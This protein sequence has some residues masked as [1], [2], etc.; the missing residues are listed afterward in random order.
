MTTITLDER[1]CGQGK[2]TDGIYKRIQHNLDKNI[3][4]L[5]AVPSLLLQEQYEKGL[6]F[7]VTLINSKNYNQPNYTT[8]VKSTLDSM[9]RGDNVIIITHKT[10]TM[11]P[12]NSNRKL[13]DL[14]ID[15]A[16]E[17]ILKI[18]NVTGHHKEVWSP[19]YD[20]NNLFS[21]E[22]K[23]I[24]QTI[25]L[26]KDDDEN[27]YRLYQD[28]TPSYSFISESPSFRTITDKNYVHYVTPKAWHILNNQDGGT[29][30]VISTLNPDIFKY[31][32]SVHIASAA[33]HFTEMYYWLRANN[34]FTQTQ[35]TFEK[36]KGN[37]KI[38]AS[39]NN[40]FK[41]SNTKRNSNPDILND[42]HKFVNENASGR[43][44][45]LR[46][47]GEMRML[48][49]EETIGHS[50]HGLNNPA[51]QNCNN[52]S[53]ESAL[54]MDNLTKKFII[55]NWLS[56]ILNRH[57]TKKALIHMRS[58]YL[59]YQV[60]MR[61]KLRNRDYNNERINIFVPDQDTAVCLMDYFDEIAD[62]GEMDITSKLVIGKP[63]RPQTSEEEKKLIK[64]E[65][66]QR[67]RLRQKL[68]IQKEVGK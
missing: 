39:D 57:E 54:V 41:W 61:T 22:N 4:T 55:D 58:A 13:Y 49:N 20:L 45:A 36:H 21:F 42:Y 65:Q 62:V 27:W 28:R 7:P 29:A 17:E 66:N 59:F 56:A 35:N 24:E 8:T 67:Y 26:S 46:N 51:L 60:V 12:N 2:T 23:T 10:F 53:L 31:Y 33:F 3:K 11:L 6:E 48:D 16:I 1:G 68:L 25:E 64:K 14:I 40:K 18:T 43:V 9:E 44:I 15:E 63:G 19:N 30:C 37:I 32:K 5:V 52:I 47:K 50:V 38:W 34:I